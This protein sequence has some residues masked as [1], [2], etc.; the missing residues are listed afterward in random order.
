MKTPIDVVLGGFP[1]DK[2][3]LEKIHQER[4]PYGSI[5]MKT[6]RTMIDPT[7]LSILQCVSSFGGSGPFSAKAASTISSTLDDL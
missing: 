5:P 2:S 1:T 3:R 7:T 6:L 4:S